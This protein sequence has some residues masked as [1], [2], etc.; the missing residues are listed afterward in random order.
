[1]MSADE[2][3]ISFHENDAK[4]LV[5][6]DFLICPIAKEL[7]LDPVITPDG[8]M[9]DRVSIETW[10]DTGHT[11]DP[12]SRN[13]IDRTKLTPCRKLKQEVDSEKYKTVRNEI[14]AER[15]KDKLDR[16]KNNINELYQAIRQHDQKL[17]V[18]S[19]QFQVS[20]LWV[21]YMHEINVSLD[22]F[23]KFF[24][25]VT[26]KQYEELTHNL[27]WLK[28][29]FCSLN[30]LDSKQVLSVIQ[31]YPLNSFEFSSE[32]KGLLPKFNKFKGNLFSLPPTIVNSLLKANVN[33]GTTLSR[34]GIKFCMSDQEVLF[35]LKQLLNIDIQNA[36]CN[37]M[38]SK[39]SFN[40]SDFIGKFN[41]YNE[42]L[43]NK[44][45][46]ERK[47]SVYDIAKL[48]P[49]V[50]NLLLENA[51]P[52]ITYL[53][54][55]DGDHLTFEEFVQLDIEVLKTLCDTK[56]MEEFN[57]MSD[58]LKLPMNF[59]L[60]KDVSTRNQIKIVQHSKIIHE[61]YSD[62]S[63]PFQ[64]LLKNWPDKNSPDDTI[65][66]FINFCIDHQNKKDKPKIKDSLKSN[67]GI[68]VLYVNDEIDAKFQF[69][70]TTITSETKQSYSS[71]LDGIF[72]F[73]KAH[74]KPL[75]L[76]FMFGG[77]GLGIYGGYRCITNY[78]STHS[79]DANTALAILGVSLFLLGVAIAYF[80]KN[81]NKINELR[82]VNYS[83]KQ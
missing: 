43:E 60:N 76:T 68:T 20:T 58:E 40:S 65:E 33:A 3:K 9:Y 49:T 8:I 69:N 83:P 44:R 74:K 82:N 21:D 61:T 25:S 81:T 48:N 6:P 23:G 36:I 62:L 4:E 41:I 37:L 77:A 42:G 51:S 67:N 47:V 13:P 64:E 32:Y 16:I 11:N 30:N 54:S 78:K 75:S 59:L 52:I 28:E 73:I 22:A 66:F 10:I 27:I 38:T 45:K 46:N 39:N 5:I 7:M 53:V 12:F 17:V 80:G 70:N 2:Q 34:L 19:K 55:D 63:S 29:C 79:F 71:K 57:T 14:I 24:D 56:N 35:D 18:V 15:E 1:M 72:H 26:S 31:S 50:R